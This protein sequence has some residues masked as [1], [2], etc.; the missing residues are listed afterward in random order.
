MSYKNYVIQL[1]NVDNSYKC[2]FEVLG[3]NCI[4]SEV[5]Q[6]P[7]GPWLKEFEMHGIKLT[8]L[9]NSTL[10]VDK[11]IKLLIGADVGGKLFTGKIIPLKSNL[12]A[13]HTRLGWTVMGKTFWQ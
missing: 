13:V 12:T 9:E 8:D 10:K 7:S 6:I 1:C 5:K 2:K 4:C 11:E 3:Q